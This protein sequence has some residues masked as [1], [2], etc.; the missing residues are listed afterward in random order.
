MLYRR[1]IGNRLGLKCSNGLEGSKARGCAIPVEDGSRPSVDLISGEAGFSLFYRAEVCTLRPGGS[2]LHRM[3]HSTMPIAASSASRFLL[4]GAIS[5]G[6]ANWKTT[7]PPPRWPRRARNRAV[8]Q[9]PRWSQRR[10]PDPQRG[11]HIGLFPPSLRRWMERRL[12]HSDPLNLRP[13]GLSE[14][15][16]PDKGISA[17]PVARIHRDVRSLQEKSPP[18]AGNAAWTNH[19]RLGTIRHTPELNNPKAA[20]M[21]CRRKALSRQPG[22][23]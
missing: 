20:P 17:Y 4:S 18:A 3:P 23:A 2:D 12:C 14:N 6:K 5:R 21:D 9:T 13:R 16:L 19:L 10:P 1:F 15:S 11:P 22:R 7:I 8:P